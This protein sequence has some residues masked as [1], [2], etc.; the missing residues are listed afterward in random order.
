MPLKAC[1]YWKKGDGDLAPPTHTVFRAISSYRDRAG[2][3]MQRSPSKTHVSEHRGACLTERSPRGWPVSASGP[4][5]PQTFSPVSPEWSPDSPLALKNGLNR[6][7]LRCTSK[8][9]RE[10][11]DVT[12]GTKAVR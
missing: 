7:I 8:I 1:A 6:K 2:I 11:K 12:R 3:K 4:F 10:P 5:L 9:K